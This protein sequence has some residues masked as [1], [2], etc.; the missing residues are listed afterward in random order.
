VLDILKA[1]D[2]KATFFEIG[3][4]IRTREKYKQMILD[5]GHVIG[6]HSWD[7]IDLNSVK[8]EKLDYQINRTAREI[9]PQMGPCMRPPYGAM[10]DSTRKVIVASGMTP[11]LWNRDTNDW[12]HASQ[13][14]IYNVLINTQPGDVILMHDG[15]GDRKNTVAALKEALPKLKDKGYKFGVVPVCQPLA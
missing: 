4:M 6:D 12:N 7:H 8:G 2:A 10:N 14:A 1:N 5:Q 11:V 15:G 13:S 9:G 3:K